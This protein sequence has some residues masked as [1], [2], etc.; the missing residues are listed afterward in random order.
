MADSNFDPIHYAAQA[1]SVNSGLSSSAGS[2]AVD[3]SA[4]VIQSR[5]RWVAFRLAIATWLLM[6]IGS[7]TRVT[8]AGLA[9]PDWPLCYGQL[10][11]WQQMNL[12][13]FLEWF[14]RL[15]AGILVLGTTGMV[16]YAAAQRRSLP[17]WILPLAIV[18]W[19]TLLSQAVLGA[20][21]V[22][23]LLRFDIVTAH[24]GTALAFF[25]MMLVLGTGLL[26]YQGLGQSRS[27]RIL[28]VIAAVAI[29]GQSIAGALV[30]S[31]WALHQCLNLQ[32]LCGFMNGHLWGIIPAVGTSLAMI[33]AAWKTPALHPWCRMLIK[34][35]AALLL[36]QLLIGYGTFR[37]HLQVEPLTVL[38]QA[39]ASGLLA[40]FV[41]F[42][43]L[44][45][46]NRVASA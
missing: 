18:A 5:L 42:S 28:S 16:G 8:N 1:T 41:I 34:G 27:L 35:A 7:A 40:I 11:P 9:C 36:L 2:E 29:Y 26:P 43:T 15:D 31:Q 23:Q 37:L 46:R 25:I 17:R 21:T 10:L 45:H 19:F 38:H 24:L 39:I 4:E 14:H 33:I 13:V 3:N 22:T 6:A 30:G 44:I 20:L 32:Q 12:Q